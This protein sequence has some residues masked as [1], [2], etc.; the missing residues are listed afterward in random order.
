MFASGWVGL[1]N[2]WLHGAVA[3]GTGFKTHVVPSQIRIRHLW[4]IHRLLG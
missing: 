1:W 3:F 2:D 4:A